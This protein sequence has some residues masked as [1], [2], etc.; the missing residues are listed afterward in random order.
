MPDIKAFT[1]ALYF[2]IQIPE[3]HAWEPVTDWIGFLAMHM[4]SS[5]DYS[6]DPTSMDRVEDWTVNEPLAHRARYRVNW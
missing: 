4:V 1:G 2:Y 5:S 6:V 3:P